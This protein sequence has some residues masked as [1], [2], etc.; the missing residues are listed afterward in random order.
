MYWGCWISG[1]KHRFTARV[2]L[3]TGER[4]SRVP[5]VDSRVWFQAG[6]GMAPS[7]NRKWLRRRSLWLEDLPTSG[8]SESWVLYL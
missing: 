1:N 4:E 7:W 6:G 3:G 5:K 8:M 2:C